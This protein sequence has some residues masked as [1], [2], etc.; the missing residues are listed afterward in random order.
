MK[1]LRFAQIDELVNTQCVDAEVLYAEEY[2]TDNNKV[3]CFTV[4]TIT[5]NTDTEKTKII[6]H[7][8][9]CD[10]RTIPAEFINPIE[11]VEIYKTVINS[12]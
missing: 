11:I 2:K 1:E 5:Y 7:L 8:K 6:N 10:Y 12:L 3:V 9:N 4:Y